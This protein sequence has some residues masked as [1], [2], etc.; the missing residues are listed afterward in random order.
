MLPLCCQNKACASL[1]A[2]G[3]YVC[4]LLLLQSGVSMVLVIDSD[5]S[6]SSNATVSETPSGGHLSGGTIIE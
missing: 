1:V 2:P 6:A 3:E 4:S 5:T